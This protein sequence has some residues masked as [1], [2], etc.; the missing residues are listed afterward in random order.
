[1]EE[2]YR[3]AFVILQVAQGQSEWKDNLC[4]MSHIIGRSGCG[5]DE[6]K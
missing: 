2:T 6:I 1:M 4:I 3:L 5:G